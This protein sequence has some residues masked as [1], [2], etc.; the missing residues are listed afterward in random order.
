MTHKEYL[1][2]A[3]FVLFVWSSRDK[4]PAEFQF[5][6]KSNAAIKVLNNSGQD[7]SDVALVVYSV[8][9]ALGNIKKDASKELSVKR[10]RDYSDVVIRFK[11]GGDMIERYAGTLDEDADHHLVISVNFAGV[12]TTEGSG[13]AEGTEEESP[14]QSR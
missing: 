7:L 2:L 3:L 4:L 10:L 13:T 6:K 5:W 12:V 9:R 11:Y 1:V 14:V 8:P